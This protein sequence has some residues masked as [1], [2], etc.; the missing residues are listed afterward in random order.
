VLRTPD[1]RDTENTFSWWCHLLVENLRSWSPALDLRVRI[2]SLATPDSRGQFQ[3]DWA[4]H[5]IPLC[6]FHQQFKP[7]SLTIPPSD[8]VDLFSVQKASRLGGPHTFKL[9]PLFRSFD[10][11]AD[12]TESCKITVVVQAKSL[13][14]DSLLLRFGNIV[15]WEGVR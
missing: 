14:G 1:G 2:L 4:G 12:W 3:L 8:V 11:Q 6:W 15:G 13:D 10:L 5:G 7:A 9:H